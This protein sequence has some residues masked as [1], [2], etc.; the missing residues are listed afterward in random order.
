MKKVKMERLAKTKIVA[1][2]GPAS[3]SYTILRKMVMA[4]LNVAR[5]NFSHGSHKEHLERLETIR[6]INKNIGVTSASFRT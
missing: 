2:L 1:T 4:G 3:T 5:F 6:K